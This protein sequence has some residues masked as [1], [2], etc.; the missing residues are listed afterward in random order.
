MTANKNFYK[1]D[2]YFLAL[3]LYLETSL[4]QKEIAEQ[5]GVHLNTVQGWLKELPKLKSVSK[6][7]EYHKA[8]NLWKGKEFTSK[9]IA[10]MVGI[11]VNTMTRWSKQWK[12]ECGYTI[13][14]SNEIEEIL[15]LVSQIE[16]LELQEQ[17]VS[18]LN[19]K[20]GVL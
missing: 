1:K 9:E 5:C 12:S 7:E 17:L 11:G 3:S 8:F 6:I 18:K 13:Y 20:G 4:S 14:T 10:S 16:D 2:A 15:F 19:K